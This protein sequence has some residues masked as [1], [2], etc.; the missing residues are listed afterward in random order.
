MKTFVAIENVV[1]AADGAVTISG[2]GRF[3][4][5]GSTITLAEPGVTEMD[6]VNAAGYVQRITLGP[7]GLYVKAVIADAVAAQKLHQHVYCGLCVVSTAGSD[8]VPVIERVCLV[9]R[10]DALGK[11]SSV[12]SRELYLKKDF[13]M[14]RKMTLDEAENGL[15][16]ALAKVR[17]ARHN[18][19]SGDEAALAAIRKA[20]S[21]PYREAD[22]VMDLLT[23]RSRIR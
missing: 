20:H 11:R 18:Q 1:S 19:R 21:R 13:E 16:T 7:A 5:A 17:S 3:E 14:P 8:G 12:R 9:D 4:D 6:G 15:L 10:P 2:L 22:G 23:K